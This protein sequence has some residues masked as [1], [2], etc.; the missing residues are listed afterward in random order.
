MFFK[1]TL[2]VNLNAILHTV[3]ELF[4]RASYLKKMYHY[5]F[6]SENAERFT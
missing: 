2:T 6:M 5:V 4:V 1:T 3:H